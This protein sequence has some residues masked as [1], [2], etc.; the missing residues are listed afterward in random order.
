[1]KKVY[2]PAFLVL[3][4]CAAAG[5]LFGQS[6]AAQV[7]YGEGYGFSILREGEEQYYD[8]LYDDVVG[9]EL[10]ESDYIS[11]DE[12]TFIEVQLTSSKNV[13]KISENTSFQITEVSG[14]GGGR[15]ALTYGRVRAKVDRLVGN[16]R[17]TIGGPTAVAGVRGTDFGYD[18]IAKR[19]ETA[20]VF[21]TLAQVY[22]FQG[23]VAVEKVEE[24]DTDGGDVI[25]ETNQMVSFASEPD[26]EPVKEEFIPREIEEEINIFWDQNRF[27]GELIDYPV[28]AEEQEEPEAEKQTEPEAAAEDKPAPAEEEKTAEEDTVFK[29]EAEKEK[30]RKNFFAAGT[31]VVGIGVLT[32]VAG[33]LLHFFGPGWF[34]GD[35]ATYRDTG[36]VLMVAGG[37]IALGGLLTYL[38]ILVNQ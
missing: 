9:L 21:N 2:I 23:K 4:L 1:M 7:I 25:I 27:K 32:E 30:T 36:T 8:V 34:S 6:S 16:D 31:T 10:F 11:T 20:E 14:Q 3:L 22:C 19:E 17:F 28:P 35:A 38:G 13:L 26:A 29:T 12:S 5:V 37:G 33:I 15:F 18:I 24:A